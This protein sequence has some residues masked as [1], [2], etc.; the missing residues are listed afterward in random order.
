MNVWIITRGNGENDW[1]VS[2]HASKNSARKALEAEVA[3]LVKYTRDPQVSAKLFSEDASVL[4]ELDAYDYIQLA[5]YAVQ[6][7]PALEA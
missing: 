1:I 5:P 6:D 3:D 7:L 2:V 4:I